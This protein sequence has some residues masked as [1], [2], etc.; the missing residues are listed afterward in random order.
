MQKLL[1]FFI[2]L[3]VGLLAS[4]DLEAQTRLEAG[5]YIGVSWYNGDLNPNRMFASPEPAYGGLAKYVF[6]DRMALRLTL[7]AAGISGSYPQKE[8]FLPESLSGSYSFDRTLLDM[9][10]MLEIS[11]FPY[12]HPVK[13]DAV[14]S[15]YMAFGLGSVFYKR[16]TED[17]GNHDEKSSFVLSL[18]FGAGVKWKVTDW[19]SLGT[20]WIFRKTFVDDL[21]L[22][23]HNTA[24]YPSN[25]YGFEH[26]T[27]THNNDWYSVVAVYAAFTIFSRSE[28]CRD[29]F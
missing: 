20:E 11:L 28:Q 12:D 7:G 13:R 8:L 17:H 15:P 25:P 16:Y 24:V 14:F 21:D 5:P 3:G 29:G 9:T 2:W 18:P 4:V 1:S 27:F 19:M 22:V 6:N 26:T 23:G 10:T